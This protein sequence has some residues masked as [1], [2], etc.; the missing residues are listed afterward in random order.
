M[1]RIRCPYCGGEFEA[2]TGFRLVVC[3]YCGATIDTGAGKGVEAYLYPARLGE[4]DAFT[5]AVSRASQL[6]GAP[7][8]VAESSQMVEASLHMVPLY[9]C[10]AEARVEGCEGA[11]EEA[12]EAWPANPEALPGLRGYR[13]PAAGREPYD[14]QRARGV[15]FHQVT[16]SHEPGCRRLEARVLSRAAS[17]AGLAR[18]TGEPVS[19]S[20]LL[21]L[22]HYP[23]WLLRYSHPASDRPLTAVVDAVDANVVLLEYPIPVE[24]RLLLL[25]GAG[26]ALGASLLVS[27]AAAALLGSLKYLAGGLLGLAPAAP[28]LGR[29]ASRVGRYRW[30]PS[31]VEETVI[32]RE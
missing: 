15:V 9:V 27:A 25:A 20:E 18:C 17:E 3:P 4:H 11:S 7:R 30:R 10:R 13:F 6:P 16:A 32:V 29:A 8:D 14:P 5:L 21:G 12:E 19:R 24:R 22:A 26:A 23:F 31:R 28:F 1:P 2:P